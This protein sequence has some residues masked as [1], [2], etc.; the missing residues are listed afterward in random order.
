MNAQ[1]EQSAALSSQLG[2]NINDI[3]QFSIARKPVNDKKAE[4][5]QLQLE[6]DAKLSPEKPDSLLSLRKDA[7][8]AGGLAVTQACRRGL[9]LVGR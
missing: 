8:R 2:I 4:L 9:E 1:R 5:L 3:L 6:N 7:G